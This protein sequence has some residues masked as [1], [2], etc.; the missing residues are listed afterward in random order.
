MRGQ[1]IRGL[2]DPARLD[3]V[4]LRDAAHI[5]PYHDIRRVELFERYDPHIRYFNGIADEDAPNHLGHVLLLDREVVGTLRI[6]LMDHDRAGFRLV[7]IKGSYKNL[8][9]GA[10]MLARSEAL[11]LAYNRRTIV[12]NAALPAAPFYR[13]HG[14]TEGNWPDVRPF[15]PLAQTRLGKCLA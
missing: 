14:Y 5:Q 7:A 3:F 11:V 10:V 12:I 15:D 13:R 9:L 8:G 6:D 1:I 4:P 2:I